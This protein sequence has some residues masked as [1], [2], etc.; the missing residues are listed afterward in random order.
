M[1]TSVGAFSFSV[2]PLFVAAGGRGAAGARAGAFCVGVVGVFGVVDEVVD[3]GVSGVFG[4]VE[5]DLGGSGALPLVGVVEEGT[6]ALP[7]EV[8]FSCKYKGAMTFYWN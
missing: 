3:E 5:V 4:V 1:V 2:V 6:L 7:G 8:G